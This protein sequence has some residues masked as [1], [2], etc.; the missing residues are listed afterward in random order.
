MF[1]VSHAQRVQVRLKAL[2]QL[3]LELAK[4]EGRRKAIALGIAAGLAVAAVVLVV[5]A[6]GFLFT[7]AAVALNAKLAL[8]LSLVVV[9]G[10]ILV[11]ASIA[12]GV[13]LHF[14]R[15]LSSPLQAVDE[16]KRTVETLKS[17]A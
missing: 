13:A 10:A 14:A 5:Y 16:A 1:G 6:I 8:W 7:A 9:A 2:A 11:L 15:K 3:T 4:I 12:V 17:H